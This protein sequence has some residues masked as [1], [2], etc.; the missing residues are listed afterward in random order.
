MTNKSL[1]YN[2]LID[3][4]DKA[5]RDRLWAPIDKLRQ[6]INQIYLNI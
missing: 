3:T 1:R 2:C 4:V 6:P 5:V